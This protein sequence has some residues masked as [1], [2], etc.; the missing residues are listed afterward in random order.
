MR[1]WL[2]HEEPVVRRRRPAERRRR[3]S[4]WV[5]GARARRRPG[6]WTL[7]RRG[8]GL[9]APLFALSIA[10]GVPL[11]R[12]RAWHAVA[13]RVARHQRADAGRRRR[14]DRARRVV[15][16]GR[17]GLSLRGRAGARS[18]HARARAARRPRADGPD[19]GRGAG[20]RRRAAS[21]ASPS[22]RSRPARSSSSSRR[23]GAARRRGRRRRRARSTRR[24]SPA[25]RCRSTR[26]RATRCLPARINGRGA[27]D[28]RVTRL[29]RDT[30]LARIIH[31]VERAQAQRAPAQTFVERFAR[32]YTPA[33]SRWRRRSP[34]CRRW[35]SADA[36]HDVDLSRA[37][38]AGRLVS[39]RARHLDAGVDRRGAGR[40][41][42]EGRA[43]QG[44]R[45]SRAR[46]PRAVRRVRQD[47]TLTRGT[48]EVVEVVAAERR[49]VAAM[50]SRWPASVEQRSEHPDRARDR[51]SYAAAA[52]VACRRPR[53]VSRAGRRGAEGRVDGRRVLLGNHRLFEER[54]L[55]SP[56]IHER[57]DALS[58]AGRTPVLVARDGRRS[59]S[60]PSPIGR[61]KRPRRHRSAATTGH[62]VDR[63]ADR[64]QPRHREG[65]RGASSAS[66]SVEPSC[67]PKTRWRPS[68]SCGAAS[69]RWRWSATA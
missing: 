32:V 33:V 3:R 15:R 31:L 56:A 2:E 6:R 43:D 27:L 61:A 16:G 45:A 36:W 44:R 35:R 55:C 49:R 24:R 60:S 48:P 11:T 26:G 57:L 13:H 67:C 63:D 17:G 14:R 41:G 66:T 30:T 53:S 46:R 25:S 19:A 42:A 18:A 10:A 51:C 20:A 29:R 37:G 23:E 5:S 68:T 12:R 38:A 54:G 50:S 52:R 59:A 34:S 8:P 47:G 65:D 69:D 64:R 1:A 62:R 39:V 40:R 21:A 58:A 4:C 28:V 22:T 7:L 9:L